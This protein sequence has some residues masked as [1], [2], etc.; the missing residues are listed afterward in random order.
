EIFSQK[1]TRTVV[2]ITLV[3]G[4][5]LEHPQRFAELVNEAD[6]DFIEAKGYVHVGYS[7]KRLERPDMPSFDEVHEFSEILGRETGY[8]VK[9]YSTDS[10]VV[11][12]SK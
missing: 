2:R 3:R 7:R 5:N 10:K 6:P 1:K 11:L 9:D 4:Y 12:L 8:S